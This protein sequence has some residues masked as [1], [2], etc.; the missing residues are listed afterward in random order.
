MRRWI[1]LLLLTLLP[2]QLCW[3]AAA[4]YCEHESGA[5]GQHFG[6]HVHV[7]KTTANSA[8][9]GSTGVQADKD[10]PACAHLGSGGALPPAMPVVQ[11]D[12]PHG[13]PATLVA[14]TPPS[15]PPARPERPN[16]ARP[17]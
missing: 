6:H 3:S 2:F 15:A 10:C 17:A 9:A 1:A 16:W 5:A 7:H 11:V 12:T 13:T 8:D 14:I 4:V